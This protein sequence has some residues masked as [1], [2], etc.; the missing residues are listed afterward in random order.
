MAVKAI[1]FDCFGVLIMPGRTLL[2]QAFPQFETEISDLEHQSD[3]GMISR[4]EFNSS[5]AE[6]TGITPEEVESKYYDVN[7]HNEE[8]VDWIRELKSSGK[9]K[10]GLLSNVGRGWLDDFLTEI[11][12]VDLFDQVVLSSDI[13]LIKP[14]VRLF[15][16]AAARLGV[17]PYECVMIDDLLPNID[18]AETAD[19]QGIVFTSTKQARIELDHIIE[20]TNA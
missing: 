10:I 7:V 18:G 12:Q 20:S 3:Y 1:I 9:Y 17:E 13:G 5:I 19:M 6:L 11:E 4:D 15:E 16:I 2:Y 14:D 8:A